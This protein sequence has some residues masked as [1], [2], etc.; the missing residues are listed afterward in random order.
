MTSSDER[1]PVV[2]AMGLRKTFG[3]SGGSRLRGRAIGRVI[4]AV[5]GIDLD[6]HHG[7][8]LGVIGESGS[9]KSTLGRVLLRLYDVD[10]GVIQFDGQDITR[11]SGHKLRQVRRHMSL[12]FQ[13]PR[14]AVNRRWR[15][16]AIVREP[17]HNFGMGSAAEQQVRA[18]EAL[19]LVG[20]PSSVRDRFP[21]ELSGGQLQRVVVARALATRPRFVVADEPTASLD[22]SVRGQ[23]VSLLQR[24]QQ[25]FGIAVLFI[26]HDL[27]TVSAVS[28]R[29]AVMYVG[30]IAELGPTHGVQS[31]PL[32]PYTRALIDALPRLDE[33]RRPAPR[34]EV[35]G[36]LDITV[37]CRYHPRCP[38]ATDRCRIENPPLEEKRLGHWAA[39]HEVPR[40]PAQRPNRPAASG[41]A[42]TE[43]ATEG[44]H[45]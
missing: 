33:V 42:P 44:D 21:H 10:D 32:H 11:I 2:R 28:D 35:T 43:Y 22:V 38:L 31:E 20:L 23:V 40:W 25:E 45:S 29:I 15:I 26:S 14:S 37:G 1:Q 18:R 9:G 34:G 36:A 7:E 39:C 8:V 5:D 16:E 13:N 27:R 17:L 4:P 3:A 6:V 30:R 41:P 12:V 19:E 24:M